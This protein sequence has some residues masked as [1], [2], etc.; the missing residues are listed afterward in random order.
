MVELKKRLLEALR[1]GGLEGLQGEPWE[2]TGRVTKPRA[3]LRI[4]RVRAVDAGFQ[5]YLGTDEKGRERYGMHLEVEFALMLLSP[6][7]GG[8]SGAEEY[9]ERVLSTLILS[10]EGA[11]TGEI[12]CGEISY[13]PKRDCFR[14]EMTLKTGV[15]AVA[16]QEDEAMLLAEI[17]LEAARS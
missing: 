3:A 12:L 10:P 15:L 9:G 4:C 8:A 17:R 14:Q 2:M 1:L 13:D 5:R 16:V 6:K 11:K 7:E